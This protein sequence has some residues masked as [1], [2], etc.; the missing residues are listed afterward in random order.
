MKKRMRLLEE[1]ERVEFNRRCKRAYEKHKNALL[2]S[3]HS[4]E[5]TLDK[6]L[7]RVF[8][9]GASAGVYHFIRMQDGKTE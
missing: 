2:N 5:D 8:L 6:T 4:S 1:S 3:S 9:D 7:R